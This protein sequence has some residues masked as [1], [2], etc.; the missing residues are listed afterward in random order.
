MTMAEAG[1]AGR[2]QVL[3]DVLNHAEECVDSGRRTGGDA[4]QPG[5]RVSALADGRENGSALNWLK[6]RME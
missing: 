3:S 5:K 4:T 2:A 6:E 1:E